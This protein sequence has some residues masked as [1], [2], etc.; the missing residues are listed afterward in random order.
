MGGFGDDAYLDVIS[1]TMKVEVEVADDVPKSE[2]GGFGAMNWAESRLE[3]GEVVGLE[4][5]VEVGG[6]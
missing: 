3:G 1:L 2:K 4:V 6:K 5:G